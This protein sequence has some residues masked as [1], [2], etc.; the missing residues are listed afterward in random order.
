VFSIGLGLVIWALVGLPG[1]LWAESSPLY[2]TWQGDTS[3]TMTVNY[4]T[5]TDTV[6]RVYYDT[7]TRGGRAADYTFSAEGTWHR[8]PGLERRVHWVELRHLKPGTTYYAIAGGGKEFKFRTAPE[9]DAPIRFV[10]GGDTGVGPTVGPLLAQAA[11]AEPLFAVIGGDFAY[12]DGRLDKAFLWH[13]WLDL[14]HKNMVTPDGYTVPLVAVIGN[15][16]VD[17]GYGGRIED[18]PFYFGLFA[19]NGTQSHYSR[20]FGDR[21]AL[22]VL[23]SGHIVAHRDQVAWLDGQLQQ[24]GGVPYRLAAY[25]VPLYPGYRHYEGEYS[26]L[27]R[28]HWGPVFDAHHLSAAFEHHDHELK[29]SKPLAG[30]RIDTTGTLYLGDGCLGRAPRV[31]RS[32]RPIDRRR[33]WYLEHSAGEAHFWRVDLDRVGLRFTAVGIDGQVLDE[34]AVPA[35]TKLSPD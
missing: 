3:T 13:E 33:R 24:L 23:D 10:V 29:R 1:W 11:A 19:Q 4:H 34:A 26:R 35:R 32:L 21:L 27:G 17:G 18:A 6:S 7:L 5:A 16:E 25:H 2:L 14:W 9:G 8:V 15:H 31:V 30:G 28:Q 12:A 22:L 20:T